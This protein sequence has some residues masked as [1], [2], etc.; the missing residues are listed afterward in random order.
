VRW[1]DDRDD[2]VLLAEIRG[3]SWGLLPDNWSPREAERI[4][5]KWTNH[6][7]ISPGTLR[8]VL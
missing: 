6:R 2:A 7:S 5:K 3:D 4:L 8:R 1:R